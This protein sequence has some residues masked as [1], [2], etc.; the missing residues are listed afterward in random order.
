M[1]VKFLKTNDP[2]KSPDFVPNDFNGLRRG[3]ETAGF[4]QRNDSFRFHVF[5]AWPFEAASRSA[6]SG[7]ETEGE[8]AAEDRRVENGAAS[9]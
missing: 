9:S 3:R 4:A 8:K 7:G 2:A 1:A 6:A 5:P